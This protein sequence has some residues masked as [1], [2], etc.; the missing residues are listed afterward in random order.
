MPDLLTSACEAALVGGRILRERVGSLG[1]VRAKS[2]VTDL[3]TEVDVASGVAVVRALAADW[4]RARFVV[5][6]PEVCDLAGVTGGSLSDDE[7]WVVDPLDG[8]T[9]YVH[10]F[11]CYSVSIALLREGRPVVGAVYNAAADQ[12]NAAAVGCGATRDGRALA[13]SAASS[14]EEALL[15]TGF[16][17]D[18]GETLDRQLVVLAHLLR[19]IQGVRR[20]GSAAIDLCHVAAGAAD[21][22][23]EFALKT[24]DT[25]A[26]ALI[27][28]EAGAVVTDFSGRPWS[29]T[30]T[31][32]LAANPTLHPLMLEAIAAGLAEGGFPWPS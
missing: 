28:A 11:P 12:M 19:R 9:S 21:G 6:E 14:I 15:V 27:A 18:R 13:V 20:D 31:D 7:V 23:W 22:F 29:S 30:T 5:E 25:A 4:P 17:Y 3:V 8:T 2:T 16:P 24:W 1:V 32:T 26:G 10:G